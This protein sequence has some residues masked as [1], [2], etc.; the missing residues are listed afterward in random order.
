LKGAK[1][2]HM[3]R[4]RRHTSIFSFVNTRAG[5]AK[6][7]KKKSHRQRRTHDRCL[8]SQIGTFDELDDVVFSHEKDFGDPWLDPRDGKKFYH[9]EKDETFKKLMRK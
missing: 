5:V 1:E 7:F 6:L 9:D 4:S 2:L 3:S 8:V